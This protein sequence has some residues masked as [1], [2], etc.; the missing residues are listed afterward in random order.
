[1]PG[2]PLSL[3]CCTCLCCPQCLWPVAREHQSL[4]STAPSSLVVCLLL[5]RYMGDPDLAEEADLRIRH[6]S[7]LVLPVH[8]LVLAQQS[9]VLKD[10]FRSLRPP[11]G[12]KRKAVDEVRRGGGACASTCVHTAC[13]VE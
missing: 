8:K 1:M 2:M 9:R 12:G 4:G 10:M 5:S 6:P 3:C 13:V 7:G 11:V